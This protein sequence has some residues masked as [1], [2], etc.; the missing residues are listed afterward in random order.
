MG[1]TYDKLVRDRIPEIIRG[2]GAEPVT[3][4]ADREEYVDRLVAKLGEEVAEFVASREPEE[5]ADVMEV[6]Y[7]LAAAQGLDEDA[8]EKL[9]RDKREQRGGFED[10]I[11]LERVDE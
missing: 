10:A 6:L 9:R 4:V 5:L 2:R 1:A 7:A 3:R 11:V 8:L